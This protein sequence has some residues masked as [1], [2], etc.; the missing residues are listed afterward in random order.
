MSGEPDISMNI[1]K[2]FIKKNL[3]ILCFDIYRQELIFIKSGMAYTN[4]VLKVLDDITSVYL[5]IFGPKL[6]MLKA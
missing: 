1:D 6:A 4:R 5:V 3:K 2:A